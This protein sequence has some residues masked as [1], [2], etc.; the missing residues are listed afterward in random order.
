MDQLKFGQ[1]LKLASD[2]QRAGMTVKEIAELP[3]YLG[4]DDELNGIHTGWYVQP[5]DTNN[6][7]DADLVELISE[8]RCNVELKGKAILI[9]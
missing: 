3:V 6:E 5:I 7:D 8:D 2:L 1:I 4:R 9:S